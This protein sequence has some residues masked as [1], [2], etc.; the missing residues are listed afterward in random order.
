LLN[1]A[2]IIS[3]I[4]KNRFGNAHTHAH[5]PDSLEAYNSTNRSRSLRHATE[6][7]AGQVCFAHTIDTKSCF[8]ERTEYFNKEAKWGLMRRVFAILLTN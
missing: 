5:I 3:L 6:C 2:I 7:L 8:T 1:H 4:E